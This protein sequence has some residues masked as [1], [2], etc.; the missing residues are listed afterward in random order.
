MIVVVWF[1]GGG[2]FVECLGIGVEDE[3][4]FYLFT[5]NSLPYKRPTFRLLTSI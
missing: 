3:V 4:F 1:G 5:L 2:K